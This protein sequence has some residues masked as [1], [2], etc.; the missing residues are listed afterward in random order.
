MIRQPTP[1]K[2]LFQWWNAALNGMNPPVH[3][4]DAQC[5]FYKTKLVK[6]GPYAAVEIKIVRDVD[7]D[8]GELTAP[9]RFIAICDGER[10][11]AARLWTYLTPISREEHRALRDTQGRVYDLQTKINLMKG[12]VGP[13]G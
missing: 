9:E 12:A 1:A 2:V 4:G 8:T 7:L 10:R 6:G 3:D 13:N 11:N 5:G